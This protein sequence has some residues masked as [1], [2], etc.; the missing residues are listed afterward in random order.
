MRH[1]IFI[2]IFLKGISGGLTFAQQQGENHRIVFYNTENLYS[3]FEDS[4]TEHDASPI[5]GF[6][7]WT[8]FRFQKKILNLYKII[9]AVGEL[10]P[11]DMVGL[12]EVEKPICTQSVGLQHAIETIPLWDSP[13]RISRPTG[14][15]CGVDL[16]QRKIPTSFIRKPSGCI[17]QRILCGGHAIYCM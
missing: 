2:I 17:M 11:P 8:Y 16:P 9:M 3:P 7:L 13:L 1:F 15:G 5:P 10:S 4:L 12:C 6:P 14:N